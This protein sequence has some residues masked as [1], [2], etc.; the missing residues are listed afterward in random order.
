MNYPAPGGRG[1]PRRASSFGG[2]RLD[3][4][5]QSVFTAEIKAERANS[6]KQDEIKG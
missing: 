3:P 1:I 4:K 5:R 6:N 2:F